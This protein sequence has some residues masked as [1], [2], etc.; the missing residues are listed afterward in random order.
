MLQSDNSKELQRIII[1]KTRKKNIYKTYKLSNKLLQ[2]IFL[3]S[4]KNKRSRR[5]NALG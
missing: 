5:F 1:P 4:K 2:L 3:I